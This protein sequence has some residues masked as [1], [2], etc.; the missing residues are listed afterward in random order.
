MKPIEKR[1]PA[2]TTLDIITFL[3]DKKVDGELYAY[4]Q[5]LS[6]HDDFDTYV[7]KRDLPKQ[8]SICEAIGVKSPKTLRAHLNYLIEQKFVEELA[9][10]YVLP[11]Q[12]NIYFL[13]PLKT[14]QFLMDNC[15][16]HVIKI[17]VYL[18][19]RWKW[20]RANGIDC[21]FSFKD[22]AM[23]IGILG[24]HEDVANRQIKNALEILQQGNLIKYERT[25][26]GQILTYFD[27][28][29]KEENNIENKSLFS[30]TKTNQS[31]GE[32]MIS[33]ILDAINIP[34]R[35]EKVFSN[36]IFPDSGY[37][38][39]FDFWVNNKYIIEYD[40]EQHFSSIQAFG[41]EKQY[42]KTKQ[43]DEF[44]N[45]WCKENNIPLIRIPYTHLNE[46]CVNDLKLETS[47]FVVNI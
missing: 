14:L 20:A 16:E 42:N 31:T 12:E 11:M 21:I 19:Q 22:L 25:K 17:Y 24:R 13:I 38:A 3:N 15:K 2:D 6:R 4:L 8:A 10:R 40:G 33:N 45:I 18:G 9:D 46:I 39:R 26:Q 1:F 32:R 7:L 5:S 30:I 23:H 47:K 36:C 27:L 28:N 44:K 41:G 35:T 37:P 43:H 34:Y 29:L